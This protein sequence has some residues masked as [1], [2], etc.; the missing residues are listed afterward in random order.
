MAVKG[1][2]L[3]PRTQSGTPQKWE[4]QTEAMAM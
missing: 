2:E 3:I 1:E 4:V